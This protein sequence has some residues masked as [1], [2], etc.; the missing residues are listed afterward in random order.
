MW[1]FYASRGRNAIG[2]SPTFSLGDFTRDE[3]G[4]DRDSGIILKKKA[5]TFAELD[6]EAGAVLVRE[7]D[8]DEAGAVTGQVTGWIGA[9]FGYPGEDALSAADG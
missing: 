2:E 1:N 4:G 3:P 8:F 6:D 5:E 9:W 7:I